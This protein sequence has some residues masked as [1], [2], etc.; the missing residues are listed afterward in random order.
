MDQLPPVPLNRSTYHHPPPSADYRNN[1]ESPFAPQWNRNDSQMEYTYYPRNSSQFRKR[2]YEDGYDNYDL[3]PRSRNQDVY[4]D[5]GDYERF[6]GNLG[7]LDRR[8]KKSNLGR[9]P[10]YITRVYNNQYNN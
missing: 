7:N 2:Y 6:P 4:Y 1:Y 9:E 10:N 5:T 8:Y 3:N